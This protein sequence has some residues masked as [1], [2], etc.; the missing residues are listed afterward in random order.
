MEILGINLANHSFGLGRSLFSDVPSLITHT[1]YNL[2]TAVR[3]KSKVYE[4]FN[5]TVPSRFFPY[6]LGTE[7]NNNNVK[8]FS[9]YNE[10]IFEKI[11]VNGLGLR[12]EKIPSKDLE[13]EL[14]FN[15][16]L[17]AQPQLTIKL[18]Q[19]DIAE[20]ELE[21]RHGPQTIKVILPKEKITSTDLNLEFINNNYRSYI[22]Q[23]VNIQ[24]FTLKE[25]E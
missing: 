21:K 20:I 18:N 1:D 2:K 8:S 12:L 14:T 24:K 13:I 10:T 5:Q 6:P 23:S 16:M 3:Q 11:F 22:S 7:I 15:A 17:S 19:K 9:V 4:N 25:R